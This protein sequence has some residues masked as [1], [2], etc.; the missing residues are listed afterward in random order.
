M[1]YVEIISG[2]CTIYREIEGD[3]FEFNNIS[4]G[5]IEPCEKSSEQNY[6]MFEEK[7]EIGIKTDKETVTIPFTYFWGQ[8]KKNINDPYSYYRPSRI[9][10]IEFKLYSTDRIIKLNKEKLRDF[11]LNEIRKKESVF[12]KI[13]NMV[14]RVDAIKQDFQ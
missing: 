1:I 8:K 13:E 2:D 6:D 10:S 12:K 14:N 11:F 4:V 7:Y 3:K 9:G 5:G